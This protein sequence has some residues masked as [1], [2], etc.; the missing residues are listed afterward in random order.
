MTR[1]P[2][3]CPAVS[4]MLF[5]G[6]IHQFREPTVDG[7]LVGQNVTRPLPVNVVAIPFIYGKVEF[8]DL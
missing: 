1:F 8:L 2:P 4:S 6:S 5:I 7:V 3:L